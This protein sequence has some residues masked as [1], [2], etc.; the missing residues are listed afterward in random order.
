MLIEFK[1]GKINK[2]DVEDITL[3]TVSFMMKFLTISDRD[4]KDAINVFK[5]IMSDIINSK[6]IDKQVIINK[7][8]SI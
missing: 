8:E 6:I 4:S 1:N 5:E 3:E 7:F 2:K